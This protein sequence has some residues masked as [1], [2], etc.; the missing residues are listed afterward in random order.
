MSGAE[1]QVRRLVALVPVMAAAAL[2]AWAH[3]CYG[4][5]S[6]PSGTVA[7]AGGA[8]LVVGAS[9][10]YFAMVRGSGSLFGALFL[11]LGLLL[12]VTAA[13]QAASR[14][15]VALC[16][17]R[18]V[19][20]KVQGSAGEGAPAEKTVY[21]HVLDCPGGY[22]DVLGDDR[23][24]ADTGAEVRVAYDARHRASPALEGENSPWTAGSWAVALLATSTLLAAAGRGPDA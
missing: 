8:V 2:Y 17:V 1:P 11:A 13:D 22:P 23:R 6:A 20:A 5:T 7:L 4:G 12:T 10:A 15:E 21:R 18:D 16:V 24:I 19:Q 3:W 14:G 9:A